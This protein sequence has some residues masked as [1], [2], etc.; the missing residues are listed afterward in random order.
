[1]SEAAAGAPLSNW[2][3]VG[4]TIGRTDFGPFSGS[5]LRRYALVSGDD[6]PLHLDAS[7]AAAVGLEAPPV[8][9]MLM[10]SC[11]EPALRHWRRDIII[12]RLSGKFL[13]PVLRDGAISITGRVARAV[14]EPRPELFLRLMAYGPNGDLAILAEA[15]VRRL[16]PWPL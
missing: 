3:K 2:P 12:C 10:M 11:F 13:R 16:E 9:G 4:E 15:T 8:H 7:A 1:M 5:H 6:N 14:L